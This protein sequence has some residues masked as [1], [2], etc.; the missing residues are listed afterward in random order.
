MRAAELKKIG[1]LEEAAQIYRE[2]LIRSP[3]DVECRRELAEALKE[4]GRADSAIS[5]FVKVQ[6]MLALRG[7][8]LGAI[9]AGLKVMEIDPRFENPLSYVAKVKTQTL[10]EEQERQ[11]KTIPFAFKP[12]G[13]IRLLSELEPR[14]LSAVAEMMSAHKMEEDETVFREGDVGDSLFFVTR[15]SVAVASGDQ[16]LGKLGPGECFG[17]FSFLAG[18]PRTASVR[19]LEPTELLELSAAQLRSVIES[20]PRLE[21]V[22][23]KMYRERALLNV[24]AHSPL[25]EMLGVE[26]RESVAA[27]VELVTYDAGQPV[28]QRGEQGRAVFLVKRGRVEVR[29]MGPDDEEVSLAIL[30]PHQFFG[31]VSFLTGVPRTATVVPLEDCELL[32]LGEESLRQLVRDYPDLEQVLHSYHLDR[33]IA[34]AETFKAFL[35]QKGIE[36]I[37][38]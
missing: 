33:V 25:F 5:E 26:D 21:E 38:H 37:L 15:G 36:G 31:E 3:R 9:S 6:E 34:T 35:R 1:R 4:T 11:V 27:R 7:D 20:H 8:V 12:L 22:L 16:K 13:E 24:L 28:F 10:C 2:R 29:A 30:R 23:Y 32:K 14:E 17:E 18:Q 19:T